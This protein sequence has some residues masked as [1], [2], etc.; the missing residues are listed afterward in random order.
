[1]L[2]TSP[3]L[4]IIPFTIICYRNILIVDVNFCFW[5][6]VLLFLKCFSDDC[7]LL[8]N[9]NPQIFCQIGHTHRLSRWFAS[10]LR[11]TAPPLSFG[12]N[13]LLFL[14]CCKK[15]L[16]NYFCLENNL[17]ICR[18]FFI[19]LSLAYITNVNAKM[20][21]VARFGTICTI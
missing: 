19:S 11:A 5:F 17:R 16:H 1:M 4:D 13:I 14:L 18:F 15:E 3:W 21:C 12:Y 7:Q 20:W 9:S 2:L 6:W 8:W 10:L